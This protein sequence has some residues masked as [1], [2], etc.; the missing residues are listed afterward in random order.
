MSLM[1]EWQLGYVLPV[2]VG[3]YIHYQFYRAA[4]DNCFLVCH[5]LDLGSFSVEGVDKALENFDRAID[6]LHYRKVDRIS[7]GGIPI[8]AYAGRKRTLGLIEQAEKRTGIPC[9]ADFEE[10]IDGLRALG[11][12]NVVVAAKW[13][14]ELM[15]RVT[16]YLGDAG[17]T[18][19]G[20]VN[21]THSAAEV[22][23]LDPPKS[24]EIALSLGRKAFTEYPQ[25]DGLLL[26]GGAWLS[27]EAVPMLEREFGRP[28]VTNPQATYWAAFRQFGVTPTAGLG[29]LLDSL[30]GTRPA[31]A[32]TLSTTGA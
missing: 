24:L 1:P 29:T 19:A 12:R 2:L 30:Q 3:D 23:A 9:S 25:A 15:G 6:F 16:D 7:Q 21:E 18:V 20:F 31:E 5:P 4:P 8:S 17:I 10:S 28:V 14:P 11:I 13:S 32:G 22:V 26:A 27:L